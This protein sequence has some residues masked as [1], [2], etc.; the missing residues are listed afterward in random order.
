MK[1]E[2]VEGEGGHLNPPRKSD[3]DDG[4]GGWH[5]DAY[6]SGHR[7][8]DMCKKSNTKQNN[9]KFINNLY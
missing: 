5:I 3:D 6:L 1:Q 2:E 7:L 8:F 9:R 4:S